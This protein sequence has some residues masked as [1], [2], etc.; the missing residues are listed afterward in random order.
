MQ[1]HADILGGLVDF[2]L[3]YSGIRFCGVVVITSALH[4]E[5][6]E[7]DPRQNLDFSL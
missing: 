2:K 6:R 4:A 5:G 1:I 7:F 3:M